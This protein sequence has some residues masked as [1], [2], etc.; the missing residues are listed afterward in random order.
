MLTPKQAAERLGVSDSLIYEWCAEGVLPHYRFGRKGRRGRILIDETEFAA[1]LASCRQEGRQG[2]APM[3]EL[4]HI[5]L[6]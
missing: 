3:P 2:A 1:F 5:Q 4:R 6:G